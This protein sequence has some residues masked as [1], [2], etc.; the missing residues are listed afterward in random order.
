MYIFFNM[1]LLRTILPIN[2]ERIILKIDKIT[3][4]VLGE[5]SGKRTKTLSFKIHYQQ[6]FCDI[7]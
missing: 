7:D 5:R 4:K 3:N 2:Y 6:Y 1:T